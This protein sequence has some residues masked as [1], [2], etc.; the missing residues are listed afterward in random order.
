MLYSLTSFAPPAVAPHPLWGSMLSMLSS[1]SMLT[2]V[3]RQ[4]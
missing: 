3:L 2:S 4:V 1:L